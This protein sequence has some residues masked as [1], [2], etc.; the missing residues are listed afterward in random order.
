MPIS[1]TRVHLRHLVH[2]SFDHIMTVRPAP[3]IHRNKRPAGQKKRHQI[4][5][6]KMGYIEIATIDISPTLTRA[7]Y[8]CIG[9]LSES[10]HISSPLCKASKPPDSISFKKSQTVNPSTTENTTIDSHSQRPY[11]FPSGARFRHGSPS[12]SASAP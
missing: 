2:S 1:H 7:L 9:K 3:P 8:N 5:P 6:P 4:R 12:V 10:P 11:T